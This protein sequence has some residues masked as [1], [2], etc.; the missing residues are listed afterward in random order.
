[1]IKSQIELY[2]TENP[3]KIGDFKVPILLKAF[4]FCE[5]LNDHA[6]PVIEKPLKTTDIKSLVEPWYANYI[7]VEVEILFE[8]INAANALAIQPLIELGCA[9]IASKIKGKSIQETR[10]FFNVVNDFT[11][12][13][14]A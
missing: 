7:D 3:V 13:E 14:E 8:L 5:H 2:G 12:E 10:Q 4:A 6:E 1:M 9:T 11:P